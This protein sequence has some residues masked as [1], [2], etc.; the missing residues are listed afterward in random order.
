[1]WS[2][3]SNKRLSNTVAN[4]LAMIPGG[5]ANPQPGGQRQPDNPV[6]LLPAGERGGDW[7]VGKL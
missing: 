7:Y 1:M 3:R 6:L 2:G 5:R 4:K